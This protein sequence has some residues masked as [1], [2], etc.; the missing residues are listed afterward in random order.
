MFFQPCLKRSF[1]PL[2]CKSNCAPAG[3]PDPVRHWMTNP[4]AWLDVREAPIDEPEDASLLGI[5]AGEKAAIQLAAAL[6]ADLLLMDDRKGV[7]AA[8][9]KG[10]RVT[11]TLGILDLAA[12]RGLVD[13]EQAINR[14]RRTTFRI[15]EAILEALLKR[16]AQ[17]SDDP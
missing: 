3:A 17:Q 16:H 9:R 11:G 13:F 1:C 14:L 6:H 5:D 10:L 2:P 7:N 12:R 15:P 4:P 8:E